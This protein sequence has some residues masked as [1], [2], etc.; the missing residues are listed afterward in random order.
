MRPKGF[1]I[2]IFTILAVFLFSCQDKERSG[3]EIDILSSE[4]KEM[5]TTER[6]EPRSFVLASMRENEDISSFTRN[7]EESGLSEEF[8]GREGLF[9]FFAPSNAAYDRLPA[10]KRQQM[11]DTANL[12]KRRELMRYYMVD[13]EM[14]VDWLKQKIEASE[15]GSY[16]F[17]TERGEKLWASYEDGRII[18]TDVLGNRAAIEKSNM[19]EYKGVY[20]VIDNVLRYEE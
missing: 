16:E 8:E 11:E 20:H 7:L 6:P 2:T 10:Q 9:T 17:T 5:D 12:E 3:G 18:L 13:G 1:K 15:E 19:N 4:E 14:T